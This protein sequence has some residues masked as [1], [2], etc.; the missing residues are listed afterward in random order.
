[1]DYSRERIGMLIDDNFRM[2]IWFPKNP[3]L[4]KRDFL[5]ASYIKYVC[6]DLQMYIYRHMNGASTIGSERL[7]NIINRYSEIERLALKTG[8]SERGLFQE[9]REISTDF[10][11]I[12]RAAK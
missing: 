5:K 1:M 9:M 7:L 11:A 4:N 2:D 8:T 3:D 6:N 12:V 10:A